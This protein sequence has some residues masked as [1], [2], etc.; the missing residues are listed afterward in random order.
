M[1]TA[2]SHRALD[3]DR[4]AALGY[5]PDCYAT[6]ATVLVVPGRRRC[7][8]HLV[9]QRLLVETTAAGQ[10]RLAAPPGARRRPVYPTGVQTACVSCAAAGR[11]K[12][13]LPRDGAGSDP[14]CIP[15][16]R[17]RTDR[18]GAADRRRLV[19]ELRERL[20]VDEPAGCAACGEPDP[21]PTCWLCGYSWLA[22]ARADHEHAQALEAAA[23]ATRFA[24]L[25]ETAE[26]RER[27]DALTAWINRLTE[28]LTAF[29][30]GDSWG[31]PVWLLADLLA[32][33]AAARTSRRGRRSALGRVCGVMAVNA[34]RRSGRRAMPGRTATA[35]LAGCGD[36]TRP[37]TDAWRRA[38]ALGWCVRVE[39]GR[40]LT[41][42]ERCATG[43]SQARAVFDITGLHHG[44]PAAQAAYLADALDIL[45]D[46][47]DHARGLLAAA[48][49][50][51]DDL[52]A[53]A[54]GWV[55]YRERVR[56]Q[57][58]RRAVTAA[59]D[60]ARHQATNFRTPHTV[61]SAM[62]VYSSLSRGFVFSPS[63]AHSTSGGRRYRRGKGRASR[64][65][66]SEGRGA[67]V[68][69]A[70]SPRE[71]RPRSVQAVSAGPRARR[72]APQWTGWAFGLA[73]AVQ[74]R[75]VWLRGAPLPRVA[76]T[77]GAALGP[78]WTAETL[79]AW[80]RKA[81]P[82]PLLVE[83]DSPVAYLRAVL[84]E[85]L[86]GPV[87][88]PH[89]ARRH[90]EHRRALVVAQAAADRQRREAARVDRDQDAVVRPGQRSAAAE[91]AFAAIR[92]RTSGHLRRVD[93]AAVV[94]AAP[95]G[96]VQEWPEVAQPGQGLP[97]GL[98]R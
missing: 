52:D 69:G 20:N 53:R 88:P 97:P 10:A 71:R 79:E 40:R 49:E 27:V 34:D 21:V 1:I 8:A 14:L 29:H 89:P 16:W 17:G 43:R 90:A 39:Q 87:A 70:G 91:A 55:D 36:S 59:C 48:Q 44:D 68:E 57:Q 62:S 83:P 32:R 7:Q 50:R 18:Q 9:D 78:D 98:A 93:R 22:E 67:R 92:A 37:V 30:A 46:L 28:T 58:M 63:I 54:G 95:A 61:S 13:G 15:C 85:A 31:R 73:R 66:T 5:C 76:A 51:V 23:V 64:S 12:Q 60:H 35:E 6:G 65:S 45:A 84:E 4:V 26:A 24:L 72:A 33:D 19:A 38:E 2:P 94:D 75:W 11:D 96:D 81:R 74:G 80:V 42:A 77:L 86:T 25:A 41:Y 82:R 56:R 47:L 3:P